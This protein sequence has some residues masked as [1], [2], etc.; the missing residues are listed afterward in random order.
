MAV[1]GENALSIASERSIVFLIGV[2]LLL[3][4][5]SSV[6]AA[7][8]APPTDEALYVWVRAD[9]PTPPPEVV[10]LASSPWV[11]LLVLAG[12]LLTLRQCRRVV[13]VVSLGLV[14]VL[15]V[16]WLLRELVSRPVPFDDPKG[17]SG[18]F[19]DLIVACLTYLAV[20]PSVLAVNGRRPRW[21]RVG[22]A[23]L[24]WSFALLAA[25]V[26]VA[27]GGSW[28]LD[29]LVGAICGVLAASAMWLW[30]SRLSH[31]TCSAACE[32][33]WARP[34][35]KLSSGR[36]RKWMYPLAVGWTILVSALLST[37]AMLRGIPR[38]PESGVIGNGL[39]GPLNLG[40]VALMLIGVLMARWWHLTGA[41]TVAVAALVL[42]YAASV[43]YPAWVSVIVAAVSFAPALLLW[44]RWHDVATLSRVL[45]AAAVCSLLLGTTV[46]AAARTNA[47][48]WGPA[49]PR[50]PVAAVEDDLVRWMWA[51]AVTPTSV[52]VRARVQHEGSTVRLAVAGT[53]DLQDP[54]LTNPVTVRAQ[55]SEVVSLTARHLRPDRR[56]Y[57]ALEVDGSLDRARVASFRTFPRSSA[58]FVFAVGA[59]ARTG[60]SGKVFDVIRRHDPLVYLNIGDFFYGD[61]DTSDAGRYLEQYDASLSAPAQAAL[62]ARVPVGY[63]WGDHD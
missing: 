28:P 41:V 26:G 3:G 59:D 46:Y 22:L 2:L 18:S 36:R 44:W 51:G 53:P 21:G 30:L 4:T 11:V 12:M 56:Y 31:V 39:E 45:V 9:G 42:G 8:T 62:Y 49:H 17:G 47:Y 50:S 13:L 15:T 10:T 32:L 35:E 16:G 38:I 54:T 25:W 58:P 23:V 34:P 14:A 1:D 63:V 5:V 27:G 33:A 61:V 52:T 60:S 29:A 37:L 7:A 6:L 48:F 20:L 55:D 24:L 40:M 43:Q 19:P 57:Y